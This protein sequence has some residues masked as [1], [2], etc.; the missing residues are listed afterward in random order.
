M[1]HFDSPFSHH[2]CQCHCMLAWFLS[3]NGVSIGELEWRESLLQRHDVCCA[4]LSW[5]SDP[6]SSMP[7]NLSTTSTKHGRER[8][9]VAQHSCMSCA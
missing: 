8:G 2:H 7:C 3:I 9:G 1:H 4:D 6:L 5:S